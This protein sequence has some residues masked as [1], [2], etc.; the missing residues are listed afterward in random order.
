MTARKTDRAPSET[1]LQHALVEFLKS[2]EGQLSALAFVKHTPNES[3]G[4]KRIAVRDR[5]TGKPTTIP[6]DVLLAAKMGVRAGV[7]D[8]EYLGVNECTIGALPPRA[9]RGC[10]MELKSATGRLSDEQRAWQARYEANGW[11]CVVFRDWPA[12]ARF[13]VRW[14]GGNPAN[15]VIGA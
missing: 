2:A 15:F 4:G 10:A 11:Y 6:L 12:A 8:F 13:W 5:K 3:F 9:Y 1:Q 7:W 14:V